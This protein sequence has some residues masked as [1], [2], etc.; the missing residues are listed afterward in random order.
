MEK[1]AK[2]VISRDLYTL[3]EHHDVLK[4]PFPEYDI[5]ITNPPF[6]LKYDILKL[7]VDSKKPFVLLLPLTMMT[8]AKWFNMF[9]KNFFHIQILSPSIPYIHDD[10]KLVYLYW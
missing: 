4:E 7:C 3:P 9:S 8:T 6:A 5:L 2:G 10:N 1:G